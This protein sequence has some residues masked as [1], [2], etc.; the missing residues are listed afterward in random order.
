MIDARLCMFC[1]DEHMRPDRYAQVDV[2]WSNGSVMPIG[3]CK[4]CADS[5]VVGTAEG[6]KVVQKWHWDYWRERGGRV[7]EGVVIV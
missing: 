6:K 7:D 5:G 2:R 1:W 4:G 3:V